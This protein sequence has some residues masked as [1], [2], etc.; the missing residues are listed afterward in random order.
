MSA[1]VGFV[2]SFTILRPLVVL[3]LLVAAPPPAPAQVRPGQG[4]SI[5]Q[6]QAERYDG[7]KARIA[8]ADFEDKMSSS[9]QYRAEY[10]RG[11]ADMLATALFNTNRFIV[12]ERQKLSFVLAE[13]DLGASG[14]IKRETAAPIGELEGAEL[15]ITAA[16]T[17]FDPGVA[18]GGGTAGG[19]LGDIFGR[20]AGQ[21][22]GNVAG[23]F[24]RAHVALDVRIVDTKTGRV[25]AANSVQG[26]ATEFSGSLGVATTTLGGALGGFAKTPM[27]RAIREAIQASVDFIVSKTPARYYRLAATTP[28]SPPVPELQ[29]GPPAMAPAGSP[30]PAAAGPAPVY[31]GGPMAPGSAAGMPPQVASIPPS[32]PVASPRLIPVDRNPT[33]IAELTEARQRGAVVSV[34]ITVRNPGAAPQRLELAGKDN[35]L[36]DYAEGK[37]YELIALQGRRTVEL[38]PN[39][40][41]VLRATFRAPQNASSVAVVIEEIGTFD[42]VPIVK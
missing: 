15:L 8:V 16:V 33:L 36:L 32:A 10:G 37:K 38:G 25:V 29:S 7:P 5:D 3:G 39:E 9:G 27:E 30:M 12:L 41:T 18:G 24:K 20:K 23:G 22:L 31:Q 14:R 28:S 17:G 26:S 11:M 1:R 21:V 42:D 35:Y 40:Q 4:P 34:A 13:Q 6:A 2:G 19:I